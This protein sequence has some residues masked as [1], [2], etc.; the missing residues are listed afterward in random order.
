MR[1]CVVRPND[2]PQ[3]DQCEWLRVVSKCQTGRTNFH[4]HHR[5]KFSPLC[6]C[7]GEGWGLNCVHK[8]KDIRYK[9]RDVH[10]CECA[11]GF[12]S[13]FYQRTVYHIESMWE[14]FSPLWTL[15]WR[16][17]WKGA[18]GNSLQ[19]GKRHLFGLRQSLLEKVHSTPR[20]DQGLKFSGFIRISGF[21]EY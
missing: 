10:R 5:R 3:F 9:K 21:F 1:R 4:T 2:F 16:V 13:D 18:G 17:S 14:V 15:I 12:S 8:C 6:V 19:P 20:E 11:Y 7:V